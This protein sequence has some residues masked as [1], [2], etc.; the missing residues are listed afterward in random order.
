VIPLSDDEQKILAEIIRTRILESQFLEETIRD[1]MESFGDGGKKLLE[2]SIQHLHDLRDAC[3][4][5]SIKLRL[6]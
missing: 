2:E 3:Y 4:N 6:K 1:E 5:I